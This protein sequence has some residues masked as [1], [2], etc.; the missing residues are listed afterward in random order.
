MR[1]RHPTLIPPSARKALSVRIR[2]HSTPA[3]LADTGAVAPVLDIRAV[4]HPYADQPPTTFQHTYL[5]AALRQ[6]N[7]R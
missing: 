2:L 6:E 3:E 5:D 7:P 1:D 4:S